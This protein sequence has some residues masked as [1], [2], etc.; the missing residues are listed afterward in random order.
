[1][2]AFLGWQPADIRASQVALVVKIPPA[3]AGDTRDA[4]SLPGLGRSPGAGR[5]KLLQD[6]CVKTP[7]DR[8]AWRATVQRVAEL[9][10]T[11]A[12]W[13]ICTQIY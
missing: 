6:Y 8:G 7:M 12:T 9:D 13:H 11:E 5:G 4:G 2:C 10:M 1:M 3:K